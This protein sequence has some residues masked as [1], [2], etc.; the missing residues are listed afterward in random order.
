V[1]PAR[2]RL[3]RNLVI[4]LA[5][6]DGTPRAALARVFD[7]SLPAVTEVLV[8]FRAAGARG[9]E[10]KGKGGALNAPPSPPRLTVWPP[11]DTGLD[12]PRTEPT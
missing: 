6:R 4:Y 11:V 10:R 12:T 9:R 3:R 7:M 2:W 5:W 1:N 8:A